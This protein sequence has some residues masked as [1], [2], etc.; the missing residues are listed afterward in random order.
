MFDR[1]FRRLAKLVRRAGGDRETA[2]VAVA[3][4]RRWAVPVLQ[5]GAVIVWRVDRE[6]SDGLAVRAWVFGDEDPGPR[7]GNLH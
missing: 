1:E 7:G 3:D 2:R 4:A 5:S 6:S